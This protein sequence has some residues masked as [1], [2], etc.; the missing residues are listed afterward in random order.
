MQ[1]NFL[2]RIKNRRARFIVATADLSAERNHTTNA[3]YPV[4]VRFNLLI[5]IIVSALRWWR[6]YEIK[7]LYAI[8]ATHQQIIVATL[9]CVHA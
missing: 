4:Y 8:Q 3:F 9:S 7:Y 1:I 6:A 5:H 2:N